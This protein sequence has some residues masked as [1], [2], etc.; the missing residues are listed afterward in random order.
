MDDNS[1]YVSNKKGSEKDD[2]SIP[3]IDSLTEMPIHHNPD[4]F[5]LHF[6]PTDTTTNTNIVDDDDNNN[7]A[8]EDIISE[9]DINENASTAG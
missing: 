9:D 5:E 8:S 1:T 3:S 6:V 7:I 2:V 4:E